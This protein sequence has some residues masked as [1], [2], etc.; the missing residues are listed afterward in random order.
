MILAGGTL[1]LLLFHKVHLVI[2]SISPAMIWESCALN[3]G[4][5]I[6][7][8]AVII[9]AGVAAPLPLLPPLPLPRPGHFGSMV[10]PNLCPLKG[11][12]RCISVGLTV[13]RFFGE[14]D[15]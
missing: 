2:L 13:G 8:S 12:L 11:T 4:L 5:P 15:K 3:A 9:R 10:A 7:F 6:G 1:S 14:L